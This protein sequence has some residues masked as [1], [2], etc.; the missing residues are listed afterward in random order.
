MV[1]NMKCKYCHKEMLSFVQTEECDNC[2]E[3]SSRMKNDI[4]LA[5][6]I[7]AQI[8]LERINKKEKP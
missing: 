6:N 7:L 5:M 2:W 4:T 3:V 8:I 1:N